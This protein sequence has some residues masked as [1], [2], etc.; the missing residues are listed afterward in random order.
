MEKKHGQLRNVE[1]GLYGGS[2]GISECL[3]LNGG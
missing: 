1:L 2:K 3:G